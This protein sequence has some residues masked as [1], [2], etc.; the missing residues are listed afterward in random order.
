MHHYQQEG[1]DKHN[2]VFQNK[3]Y[4]ASYN[5]IMYREHKMHKNKLP[6][7]RLQNLRRCTNKAAF[8]GNFLV[9]FLFPY[10]S[11][12]SRLQRKT[13]VRTPNDMNI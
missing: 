1:N 2:I 6:K 9:Y 7:L 4:N 5:T 10:S 13:K 8:I 12:Y 3:Y 11:I